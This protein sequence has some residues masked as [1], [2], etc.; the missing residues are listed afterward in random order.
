GLSDYAVC[1][2]DDGTVPGVWY[3]KDSHGALIS[4]DCSGGLDRYRP[5]TRWNSISDGL[6]NTIFLGEKHVRPM[7]FGESDEDNSVFNGASPYT[8]IRLAG[9]GYELARG[10]ADN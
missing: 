9:P 5:R 3:T 2:G 1:G 8:H 7:R 10:T 4:A 6:S